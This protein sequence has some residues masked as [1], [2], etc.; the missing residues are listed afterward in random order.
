MKETGRAEAR[1]GGKGYW[2]GSL[3]P[4]PLLLNRVWLSPG[5]L[6]A[7]LRTISFPAGALSGTRKATSE[8]P[9]RLGETRD[10]AGP[11]PALLT[12]TITVP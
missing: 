11:A 12:P 8:I 6:M 4:L 3:L 1:P 9:M 7:T 2:M 5:A 10:V